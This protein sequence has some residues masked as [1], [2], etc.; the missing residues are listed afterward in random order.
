GYTFPLEA[1]GGQYA[2]RMAGIF[3]DQDKYQ[4]LVLSSR[5][6]SE[7]RLNWGAWADSVSHVIQDLVL[8][9]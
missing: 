3:S 2:K 8:A 9:S 4:Q 1:D 6:A 7:K 5:H